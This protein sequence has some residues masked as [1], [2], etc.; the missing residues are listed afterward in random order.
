MAKQSGFAD[1]DR[2][3]GYA[4]TM[5]E[6]IVKYVKVNKYRQDANKEQKKTAQKLF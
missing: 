6:I 4:V 2:R 3:T 1:R 5:S